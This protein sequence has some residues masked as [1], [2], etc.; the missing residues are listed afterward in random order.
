MRGRKRARNRLT[1]YLCTGR[2]TTH[3]RET[4]RPSVR[5][6]RT[7]DSE[8]AGLDGAAARVRAGASNRTDQQGPDRAQSGHPLSRTAQAAAR[9]VD[10]HEIGRDRYRPAG[11]ILL[12][13]TGCK[14]TT[15][16]RDRELGSR[17][18]HRRSV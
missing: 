15:P 7:D 2:L 11:E 5:H 12:D 17:D 3:E 10:Y 14:V 1:V 6:A 9:G 16:G 13:Y 8:D 18:R 4:N